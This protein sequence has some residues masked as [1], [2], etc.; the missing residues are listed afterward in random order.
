M[1]KIFLVCCLMVVSSG[2]AL[3]ADTGSLKFGL[4][5]QFVQSW[6]EHGFPPG[7]LALAAGPALSGKLTSHWRWG[8]DLLLFRDSKTSRPMVT[9][10]PTLMLG[11]FTLG[12]IGIVRLNSHLDQVEAWGG[13]LAPGIKIGKAS[14]IFPCGRAMIEAS[15]AWVNTVSLKVIFWL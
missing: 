7:R 15:N 4:V 13:A 6:D 8:G 3:A 14:V 11:N 5:N 12:F 9:G 2:L 10:G 1:T